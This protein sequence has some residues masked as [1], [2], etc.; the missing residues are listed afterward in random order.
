MFNKYYWYI[1]MYIDTKF[2]KL[3]YT[4]YNDMTLQYIYKEEE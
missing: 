1:K 2:Y 3:D 4:Y